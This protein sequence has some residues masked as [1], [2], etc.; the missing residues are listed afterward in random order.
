MEDISDRIDTF[1]T[2]IF[3]NGWDLTKHVWAVPQAFGNE[4]LVPIPSAILITYTPPS[5]IGAAFRQ[6]KNS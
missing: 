4:T 3:N 2:R 1:N 5:A 6:V